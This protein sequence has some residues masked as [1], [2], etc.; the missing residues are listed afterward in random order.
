MAYAKHSRYVP[1]VFR[2]LAMAIF[3]FGVL[4]HAGSLA[5]GHEAFVRGVMSPAI[6]IVFGLVVLVGAILGQ[7]SWRRFCGSRPLRWGYGFVMFLLWISVPIHLRTAF[8]RSTDYLL[9]FP[10]WYSMVEVPMFVGLVYMVSRLRFDSD[11]DPTD[12]AA[13]AHEV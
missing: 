7:L 8:T 3:A 10:V 12:T 5:I 6:D 2:R 13:A 4:M 1:T 9:A 11:D